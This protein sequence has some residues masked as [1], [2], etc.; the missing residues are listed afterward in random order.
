[1]TTSATGHTYKDTLGVTALIANDP[2][3][4]TG[5]TYT[6]T[7]LNGG[8]PTITETLSAIT[9]KTAFGC[10]YSADTSY[11]ANALTKLSYP[12]G[13]NVQLTYEPTPGGGGYTGRIQTITLQTGGTITYHYS[14][15]GNGGSNGIDC[16][17]LVPPTMTRVT[18]DG[19]TKYMWASVT[20]S[21]GTTIGNTTTV[22]DPGVNKI[23]YTFIG[24]DSFGRAG[25]PPVLLTQVQSWE[26]TGTVSSPSYSLLTTDVICY[27]GATTNCATSVPTSSSITEKDVYH[28]ISGMSGSSRTQIKY[29]NYGNVTFTAKYDFGTPNYAYQTTT[30]YGT[31]NGSQCVAIGNNINDRPCNI[32]TSDGTNTISNTLFSYDPHGNPLTKSVWTGSTWLPSSATYNGNGTVATSTDVNKTKTTYTYAGNGSGGCNGLLLTGTTTVVSSG[33]TLTTSKTW[34]CNG[35]VPLTSTD[36]NP[37]NVTQYS[38]NDPYFRLTSVTDP[39]GMRRQ[40]RT[41][42][43]LQLTHMPYLAL[44]LTMSRHIWMDSEGRISRRNR[45]VLVHLIMIRPLLHIAGMGR[46]FRPGQPCRACKRK[47]LDAPRILPAPPLTH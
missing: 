14:G 37:G 2:S 46:H 16:S 10:P 42:L 5:G 28:T 29:D 25:G 20:N 35:A 3:S 30:Y 39:L 13:S 11:S 17:P 45:R 40:S 1:M 43:Q 38:Y 41:P 18:Q 47:A 4:T 26:N 44:P 19:T 34:D 24:L 6:W 36:A 8:S 9:I 21:T 12:D 31:W 22:L 33:D 15:G 32:W 27:N 7:D 23:V